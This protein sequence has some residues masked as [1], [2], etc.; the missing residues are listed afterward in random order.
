MN[1]VKNEKVIAIPE[2][3]QIFLD[4]NNHPKIECLMSIDQICKKLNKPIPMDQPEHGYILMRNICTMSAIKRYF[5][6]HSMVFVAVSIKKPGKAR[7]DTMYGFTR[8]LELLENNRDRMNKSAKAYQVQAR[9]AQRAIED[10]TN[11]SQLNLI[12]G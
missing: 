5:Y 9:K 6:N 11:G 1:T 2:T 12:G 8:K 3:R 7:A 4:R 10:L